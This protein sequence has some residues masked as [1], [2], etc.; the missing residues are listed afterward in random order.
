MPDLSASCA[1]VL[2][3]TDNKIRDSTIVFMI[4]LYFDYTHKYIKII[5]NKTAIY[6][7]IGTLIEWAEFTFYAYM[8]QK[9][10]LLFPMFN[11]NTA[12]LMR[13]ATFAISYL[14]RPLGGILFGHIGDKHGRNT[15]FS[16]SIFLM[17]IVTLCMGILPTYQTIGF[18]APILLVALRFLQGIA[19]SG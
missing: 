7:S 9:F 12:I 5:T 10:A 2:K 3:T 14:A 17:A 6:C 15:A 18:L 4:V 19:V 11:A 13:F 16:L 8:S 1:T